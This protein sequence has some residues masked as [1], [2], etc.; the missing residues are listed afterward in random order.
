MPKA[1]PAPLQ[2]H[3]DSGSTC[4]AAALLIQ[5]A[6]GEVFGF[7]SAS[8]PLVLDLTPW[9]S[10]PWNLAGL[11]AFEFTS[12]QGLDF[13][14][15]ES[16][17]G[18]EVD[19]AEITTLNDGSL[20]TTDDILAGR[21]RGARF[22]IFLYRWDVAV[23]T[24]AADVE[25]LKVGTLG[26]AKP[27]STVVTVELRCLKQQL[28][29]AVGA[30]S[31]PNCRVRF[32]S[33]GIGQCNKDPVAFT[34][35]FTVTSVASKGQFTASAA[36]QPADYFGYGV[37]TW[38]TGLNHDLSM[39]VSTFEA[40]VFTLSA[41]MV[42]NVAVGD[43]FQVVAGCRGRFAE[44]CRDKFNNAVNFQ[45]EKDRPTRDRVVSGGGA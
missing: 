36:T 39:Q 17:A 30:V 35:T 28:Q 41:P 44:D 20:F 6:D 42:F 10:A 2:A 7:T 34:H 4:M 11:T 37:L 26:E 29:Q 24:I 21:W 43:T 19:N 45:G 33:Q 5:R 38:L 40:G 12:S 14:S 27:L 16:T 22:R 18:F 15:L 25:T 23:P 8:R 3:Y 9:N 31:Q 1:I 13:S 32:G